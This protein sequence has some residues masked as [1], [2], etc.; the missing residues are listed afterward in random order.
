MKYLTQLFVFILLGL[1]CTSLK[2]S[3]QNKDNVNWISF[4]QLNDSLKVNPK[5]VFVSFYAEWCT[6]CKKMDES[7][8]KDKN[9]ILTLNRDYYAVKMNI[10]SADT[11]K[12]GEQLFLNKRIKKVNPI[13]EIALLL[14]SRKDKIF[15]LP[16]MIF[17]NEKFIATKR[18]FQYINPK[19]FIEIVN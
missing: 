4:A 12:F 14:A 8:F 1:C 6:F 19:N 17:F 18:Y 10:E 16:A 7:T 3:A 9:V 11:I 5:K 13:H 2:S 15:S